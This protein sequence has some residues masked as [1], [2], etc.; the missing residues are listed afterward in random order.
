MQLLA[1]VAMEPPVSME[2]DAVR[3]EKVKVFRAL[4]QLSAP[5]VILD[6][7]RGQYTSGSILGEPVKGYRDEDRVPRDSTTPTYVALRINID[8]WRWAGVPFFLRHGKR[9]PKRATEIAIQFRTPPMRLFG[10]ASAPAAA[11][12]VLILNIQ[13][14]EGI[15]L[16]IGSK[17]PGPD[18][19]I[20]Q[21]KMDFRYGHSFGVA[22]PDAYERL[23]LD[24]ILGDST[25]FTRRDEVEHAWRFFNIIL[26]VWAEEGAKG[27]QFYP[28]GHWGPDVA[29]R[30]F[31]L[32]GGHWRR[33]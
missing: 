33:M 12:N 21:V 23:L 2:A 31:E 15:S 30:L 11:P 26:E 32:S 14:D 1:L 3:D 6:T 22:S 19:R 24:A 16:C 17:V 29:D 18:V 20:R 7:I 13:P 25:L 4:R 27:L 10:E 28:A 5:D 9:L 8:N